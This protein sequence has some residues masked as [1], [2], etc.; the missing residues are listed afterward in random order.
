[1]Y[2]VVCGIEIAAPGYKKSIIAPVLTDQLT[3]AKSSTVTPYG[4]ILS[5]WERSN[6]TLKLNVEI[7]GNTE[8]TI[9]FPIGDSDQVLF[10]GQSLKSQSQFKILANNPLKISVGS[11]KYLFEITK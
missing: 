6:V 1:M 9:V 2:R 8:S 4:Q 7:P 3:Y 5:G 10:N 11:G